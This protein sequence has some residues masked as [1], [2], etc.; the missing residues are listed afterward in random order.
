MVMSMSSVVILMVHQHGVA[1][2]ERE[3]QPPALVDPRVS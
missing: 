2:L 3:G 1:V